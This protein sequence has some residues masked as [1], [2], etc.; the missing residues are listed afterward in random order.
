MPSHKNPAEICRERGWEVG[1]KTVNPETETVR[2]VVFVGRDY[3]VVEHASSRPETMYDTEDISH[4]VKVEPKP[5]VTIRQ[6]SPGEPLRVLVNGTT[7]FAM[8]PW[9]EARQ[10]LGSD[11]AGRIARIGAEAIKAAIVGEAAEAVKPVEGPYRLEVGENDLGELSHFKIFGPPW[12]G[13]TACC[14][15]A[16]EDNDPIPGLSAHESNELIREAL[17]G[18]VDK[19][20][21]RHAANS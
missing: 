17:Q 16:D 5:V 14:I 11:E 12:P 4:W 13:Q 21:R 15:I 2:E 3:I 9:A 10:S 6:T 1:T 18:I 7:F 8:S 19:L 20:N